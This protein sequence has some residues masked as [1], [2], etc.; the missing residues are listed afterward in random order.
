MD[1]STKKRIAR[2]HVLAD[3]LMGLDA[4]PCDQGVAAA[5]VEQAPVVSGGVPGGGSVMGQQGGRMGAMSGRV[6]GQG[7]VS[8]GVGGGAVSRGNVQVGGGMRELVAIDA[9]GLGR[10]DKTE[11]LR[12]M[13]EDEVSGCEKCGLC[14][15]RTQVVFG[16]GDVDAAVMFVGEGPGYHEDVQGRP[17]VGKSGELLDKQIGA[18]QMERG[19]VYI[20]NVVKCRPPNNRTP[21]VEEVEAC[22]DYL[23]R[24][25]A[26][27]EPKVIITLGGPAAKLLLD[28]TEGITRLRGRWHSYRGVKPGI[29]VMPTFHPAYLLRQYTKENRMKV[30]SDLQEAMKKVKE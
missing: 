7:G 2:Q 9:L 10:E 25:I 17:F 8:G 18:M 6:R 28:T 24:Q 15:G 5:A 16:E 23:Q 4:V 21:V 1:E 29:P 19:E 3:K 14:R 26:I 22:R 13:Y 12:R 30:W 11:R 27:I 20:A